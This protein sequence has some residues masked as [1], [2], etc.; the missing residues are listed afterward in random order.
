M[1]KGKLG[2]HDAKETSGGGKRGQRLTKGQHGSDGHWC[3][4][5]P[6]IR[7]DGHVGDGFGNLW[8]L[9]QSRGQWHSDRLLNDG[10]NAVE[11]GKRQKTVLIQLS[12]E[13]QESQSEC[14]EA[15]PETE[16]CDFPR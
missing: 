12:R 11:H 4:A 9:D 1:D 5:P 14:D 10:N 13:K 3:K 8:F 2:D 6:K 16:T 15:K 7:V